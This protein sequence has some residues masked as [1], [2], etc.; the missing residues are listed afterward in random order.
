MTNRKS[1][2]SFRLVPKSVTM[3]DIERHNG[4][5]LRYFNEFGK[6]AFL[7]ITAS[8]SIEIIGQKSASV[9][10]SGEVSVSN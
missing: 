8:S 5:I 4:L 2:I 10:Q 1:Y 9:T 7:L 6:P 3:N